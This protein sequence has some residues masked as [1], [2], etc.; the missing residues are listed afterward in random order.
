MLNRITPFV[1]LVT[2][3]VLSAPLW[4][5]QSFVVT[6]E[7][8]QHVTAPINKLTIFDVYQENID[9]VPISL[10]WRKV[11]I[12]L[13]PEWDYSMCE[14]GR[15]YAGIPDSSQM[16]DVAPHDQAFLGLNI[17]PNGVSGSGIV[18][19]SIF[20]VRYPN[21]IDTITWFVTTNA[22]SVESPVVAR[23]SSSV[24]PNPSSGLFS[25][26]FGRPFQGDVHVFDAAGKLV[27]RM[28]VSEQSV[29]IDLSNRPS[30]IYEVVSKDRNGRVETHK[31][32]KE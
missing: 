11:S 7:K 15:C 24:I 2:M 23:Q 20:D 27:E 1:L 30:G 21:N 12:E 28:T 17:I 16:D 3:S 22:A 9:T 31:I 5:Q 13:P 18:R 14:L 32:V 25:I 19:C 8:D 10:G 29:L 6:P 4:A 26:D